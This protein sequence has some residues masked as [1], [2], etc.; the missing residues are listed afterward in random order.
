MTKVLNDKLNWLWSNH[1]LES[2]QTDF[3]SKDKHCT[4]IEQALYYYSCTGLFGATLQFVIWRR[5]QYKQEMSSLFG[6]ETKLWKQTYI[7]FWSF[8]IKWILS[9]ISVELNK[10]NAWKE[11]ARLVR[12][13]G[14]FACSCGGSSKP[15]SC[16]VQKDGSNE[17]H[18]HTFDTKRQSANL[19][20][21]NR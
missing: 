11:V 3:N 21:R 6:A 10:I 5:L 12:T 20:H 7:P 13:C 19:A 8:G 17:Q 1:L 4:D 18:Y 16:L 14:C 15:K 2:Y 9:R